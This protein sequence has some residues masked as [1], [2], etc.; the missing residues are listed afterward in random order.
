MAPKISK[1]QM[2][3]NKD[4]RFTA[5]KIDRP[6]GPARPV[7]EIPLSGRMP[8]ITTV[9]YVMKRNTRYIAKMSAAVAYAID[10]TGAA[11][12][13]FKNTENNPSLT[14]R[15]GPAVLEI[16]ASMD[17][18]LEMSSADMGLLAKRISDFITE[19]HSKNLHVHCKYG[20]QRSLG[21]VKGLLVVAGHQFKDY[22]FSFECEGGTLVAKDL[23]GQE[24]MLEAQR[25]GYL[26]GKDQKEW[27]R[28]LASNERDANHAFQ[29]CE[30]YVAH[31]CLDDY[32]GISNN[33]A[34]VINFGDEVPEETFQ[35]A[36]GVFQLKIGD[37]AAGDCG[38]MSVAMSISE[39]IRKHNPKAIHI[40]YNRGDVAGQAF[41][42]GFT[43]LFKAQL[44]LEL[45]GLDP[46]RACNTYIHPSAKDHYAHAVGH[47]VMVLSDLSLNYFDES[48]PK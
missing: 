27:I 44:V 26:V 5:R 25:L 10:H 12:I 37:E 4:P 38:R 45:C 14:Y 36:A 24:G 31:G 40:Y 23:A 33:N 16:A 20:E 21:F 35:H 42:K 17:D 22:S 11:V 39:A 8:K 18:L 7:A 6:G 2:R 48:P 34:L 9:A 13:R 30:N 15:G 29:T 28:A 47:S 19:N 3:L 32:K 43:R 46:L 41:V 1:L